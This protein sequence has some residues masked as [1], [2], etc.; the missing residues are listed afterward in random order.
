MLHV[1]SFATLYSAKKLTLQNNHLKDTNAL[2]SLHK[3][4]LV[5]LDLRNNEVKIEYC[6]LNQDK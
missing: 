1:L 6:I 5:Y 3:P 2:C 4:E